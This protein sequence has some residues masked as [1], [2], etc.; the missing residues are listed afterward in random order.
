MLPN[1]F[2]LFF[3]ALIAVGFPYETYGEIN[4]QLQMKKNN[5]ICTKTYVFKKKLLD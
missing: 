2:G 3:L 5:Y 4:F 1:C